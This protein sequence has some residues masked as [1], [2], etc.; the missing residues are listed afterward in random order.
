MVECLRRKVSSVQYLRDIKRDKDREMLASFGPDRYI[1]VIS[2]W[3]KGGLSDTVGVDA[4]GRM[5]S[6]TVAAYHS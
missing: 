4:G 2:A 1:L 3:G 6:F 5:C